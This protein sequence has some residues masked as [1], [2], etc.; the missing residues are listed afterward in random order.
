MLLDHAKHEGRLEAPHHHLLDPVHGG[1][2]RPAPAVGVEHGNGVEVHHFLRVLVQAAHV[3]R[4]QVKGAVRERD[5]LGRSGAAAGIEQL[6]DR[7][8]VVSENVGA[9]GMPAI[10]QLFVDQ[11]RLRNRFVQR[12]PALHCGAAFSQSPGHGRE[13]ALEQQ[14]SRAGVIQDRGELGLGEAHIER[15]H[16]PARLH[17][18]VIALEQLVRV[19]TQVRD[20]VRGTDAGLRQGRRQALAPL[21]ELGI[22]ELALAAHDAG[23]GAENVNRA[24]Q[25]AQGSERNQHDSSGAERGFDALRLVAVGLVARDIA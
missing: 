16:D 13:I 1:G 22:R 2:L 19:E 4:V 3:E 10:E 24:V 8:L 20:A 21:A 14:H 9:L 12:H 11:I 18:A 15:H 17:Y 6:G 5:A 25:T 7:H 23:L